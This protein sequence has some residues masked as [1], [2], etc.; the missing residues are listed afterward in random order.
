MTQSARCEV[1]IVSFL[2]SRCEK[3]DLFTVV[4]G[5]LY[6][7]FEDVV[8]RVGFTSLPEPGGP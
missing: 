3:G 5:D 6:R 4:W 2:L 8:S 1:E 7:C